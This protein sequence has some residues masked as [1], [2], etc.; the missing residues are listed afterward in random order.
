MDWTLMEGAF[1]IHAAKKG[2][3]VQRLA[4]IASVNSNFTCSREKGPHGTPYSLAV[5]VG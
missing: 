5:Q 1:I 2:G 3:R 4:H